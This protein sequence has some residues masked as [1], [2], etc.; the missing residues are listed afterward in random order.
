M[1]GLLDIGGK[2]RDHL[3]DLSLKGF[4]TLRQ[5]FREHDPQSFTLGPTLHAKQLAEFGRVVGVTGGE[6]AFHRLVRSEGE[7]FAFA[8][9][10]FVAGALFHH[11]L[12]GSAGF[13]VQFHV[14]VDHRIGKQWLVAT[15]FGAVRATARQADCIFSS[16]FSESCGWLGMKEVAA[17]MVPVGLR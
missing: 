13:Q 10:R 6:P 7:D 16:T 2:I 5:I 3:L 14:V 8:A 11:Q 9:E 4:I 1:L 15:F 17:P 12:A